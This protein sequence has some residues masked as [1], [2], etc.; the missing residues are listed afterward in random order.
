MCKLMRMKTTCI[1]L[2]AVAVL[3]AGCGSGGGSGSTGTTSSAPAANAVKADDS[4]PPVLVG[5]ENTMTG[6]F[7]FPAYADGYEAGVKYVNE[8]L[9]GINGSPLKTSMCASDGTP[10]GAVNCGNQFVQNKVVLSILGFDFGADAILPVLK[11]AGIAEFGYQALTPGLNGAV[12]QAF[13]ASPAS[14]EALSAGVVAQQSLGVKSLATVMPD[15]PSMRDSFDTVV[16]PAAQKLGLT[17][18]SFYY[19]PTGVDWASFASSVV[20]TQ[21]E[22]ITVYA[23][24]ADAVAAIPAFRSTGFTGVLDASTTSAALLPKLSAQQL[25]KVIFV[26]PFFNNLYADSALSPKVKADIAA[27]ERYIKPAAGSYTP[28]QAGFFDAVQAADMLR[29]VQTKT[30]AALTGESVLKNIAS[31]KGSM[32]FRDGTY[33][34]ATPSWPGTSSCTSGFNYA[35]VDANKKLVPL[36]NSP[37]NVSAVKPTG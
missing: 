37:I 5:F 29:Q 10:D 2:A 11:S 34:C 27:F 18:R 4:K 16:A 7:A 30:G 1:T 12:G 17:A 36:A 23:G 35:Q 26:N 9:G 28:A 22:G 33:D 15:I 32:F 13:F 21:P 24:D 20:A 19:P 31:T 25:D 6:T 14:Q 8:E 3:A